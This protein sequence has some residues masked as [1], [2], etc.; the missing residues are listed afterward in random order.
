MAEGGSVKYFDK[1][2]IINNK[3]IEAFTN[4]HLSTQIKKS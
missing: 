1:P 4:P 3:L 2:L